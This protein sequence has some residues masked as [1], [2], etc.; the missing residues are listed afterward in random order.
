MPVKV[1]A[2]VPFAPELNVSPAMPARVIT[3]F[4]PVSVTRTVFRSESSTM[5]MRLPV[6]DE[7]TS[8]VSSLVACATGTV[9]TG[10]SFTGVMVTN[11]VRGTLKLAGTPSS[12]AT[13][14]MRRSIR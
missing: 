8:A 3:P 13:T 1:I 14:V 2:A 10:A 11:E 4:V 6:P 12:V 5:A 7:K 9:F